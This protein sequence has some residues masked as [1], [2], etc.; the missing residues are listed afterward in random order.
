MLNTMKIKHIFMTAVAAITL[1]ATSCSG[2]LDHSPYTFPV[3]EEFWKTADQADAGVVG[4]YSLLRS[5]L[6][7][8]SRLSGS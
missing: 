4:T 6:G 8:S 2:F 1:G 5:T 3:E 7:G